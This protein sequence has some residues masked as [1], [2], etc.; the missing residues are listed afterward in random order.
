[1]EIGTYVGNSGSARGDGDLLS[2]V[3]GGL[4]RDN[5]GHEGS[6][7]NGETHLDIG[8]VWGV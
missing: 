6:G 1:M 2:G 4:G 3:D 8:F 5:G 7:D